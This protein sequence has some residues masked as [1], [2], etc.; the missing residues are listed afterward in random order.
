[1]KRYLKSVAVILALTFT[2]GAMPA[3]ANETTAK[4]KAKT[5]EIKAQVKQKVCEIKC[6]K[7]DTCKTKCGEEPKTDK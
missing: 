4:V 2:A 6:K 1:M 5:A 7:D 3:R